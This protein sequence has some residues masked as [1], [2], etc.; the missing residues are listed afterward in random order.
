VAEPSKAA[1]VIARAVSR[2]SVVSLS[3][4]V[5]NALMLDIDAHAAEMVAE[6]RLRCRAAVVQQA[7]RWE[8]QPG[9]FD[10]SAQ[11]L[12]AKV[13]EIIES[14]KWPEGVNRG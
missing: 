5:A 2:R 13:L 8:A 4:G 9:M 1:R 11:F 3:P 6:E 14:G 7:S 10:N 12:L